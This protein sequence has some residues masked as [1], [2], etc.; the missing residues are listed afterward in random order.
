M[1]VRLNLATAPLENKRRFLLGASA[2]GIVA[3]VLFFILARQAYHDWRESSEIR[4]EAAQL[5]S[6]M[7]ELRNVRGDLDRAFKLPEAH[8]TMDRAAFLN[9]L[10]EQRS[11]PWTRIFMDLERLLPEGVRV[12]SIAPRMKDGRVEVKLVV[13]ATSDEAKLM[14][15][16]TLE[17]AKEFTGVQV[18]SEGRP[19]RPDMVEGVVL[20]LLAWYSAS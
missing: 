17:G 7:R 10:I 12:V 1:K 4:A 2:I 9:G 16:K 3:L 18:L 5:Q 11:F 15:L 19:N 13:G 6:Q 20:E 8:R 14:F